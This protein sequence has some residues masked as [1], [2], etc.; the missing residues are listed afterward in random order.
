MC[1]S[2][3]RI[4]LRGEHMHEVNDQSDWMKLVQ[5]GLTTVLDPM[6]FRT[7]DIFLRGRSG[8]AVGGP[9]ISPEQA[10]NGRAFLEKNTLALGAVPKISWI[11][12]IGWIALRENLLQTACPA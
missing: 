8:T 9:P 4:P 1:P 10:E 11:I 3:A 7:G 5:R 6:V 2:S 12:S